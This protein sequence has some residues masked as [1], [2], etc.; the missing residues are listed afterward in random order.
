MTVSIYQASVPVFLRMLDNLSAILDKADAHCAARKVDPAVLLGT[1]LYPDM[2]PLARQ[3]Q[4]A[5]DFAK[6]T[7]G[8]L[9]GVEVPSYPDSETT[10]AELKARIA[11]T[12]EFVSTFQPAQID[13]SEDRAISLKAGGRV[14]SFVG[15]PYLLHFALP[16]FYFHL[17]TAY[18]ILRE[19]GVELGKRD[20]IGPE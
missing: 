9:A 16:N 15:Q 12:V 3:V 18:A 1:R 14:L 2:F 11:R 20:F 6:G 7:C 8:R 19:C 4:I 13:G 5:C 17:T 10:I